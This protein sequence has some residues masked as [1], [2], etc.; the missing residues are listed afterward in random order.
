MPALGVSSRNRVVKTEPA[1]T[2]CE[3]DI[4]PEPNTQRGVLDTPSGPGTATSKYASTEWVDT[5]TLVK[6][7]CARGPEEDESW[8]GEYEIVAEGVNLWVSIAFILLA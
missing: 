5:S 1:A 7:P 3:P 6:F 2:Q 4:K 8:G